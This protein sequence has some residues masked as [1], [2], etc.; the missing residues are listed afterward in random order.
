MTQRKPP[1]PRN[2][3]IG[4][5]GW[6]FAPWRGSFYPEGL[7]QKAELAHAS[8]QL[9]SL[10][11]NGTF[12]RT[13]TP[14]TFQ[15]WHDAA[16]EDFVFALKAPRYATNRKGLAEAGESIQRFM[17]SGLTRL[18]TKLGPINWQFA[19]NKRFDPEDLAAFLHLLPDSAD[20]LPLRHALELRHESFQDPGIAAEAAALAK[21]RN[22]ALV[23]AGDSPYPRIEEPT[24]DFVYA[25]IMGTED[26]HPLGYT[27]KA[28]DA[29]AAQARDWASTRD[30]YLY[31]ISGAKARNPAAARALITRL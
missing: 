10:E 12:Y 14:E 21:A 31:V 15:H 13:Q 20:G 25:R 5:G 24:A 23:V 1:S 3:R 28:L 17:G 27:P 16:P 26:T 4:I 18:H 11:V 29:W 19:P 30:V 22:V 9:T 8:R 2:I 7:P 6:V